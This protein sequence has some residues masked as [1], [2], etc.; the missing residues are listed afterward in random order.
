MKKLIFFGLLFLFLFAYGCNEIIESSESSNPSAS[1]SV[2]ESSSSVASSEAESGE[3][4]ENSESDESIAQSA[5][6][7]SVPAESIPNESSKPQSEESNPTS[8]PESSV[9]PP[10]QSEAG[11]EESSQ[12]IPQESSEAP[13]EESSKTPPPWENTSSRPEESSTTPP[14]EES[15][16]YTPEESSNPPKESKPEESKPEESK[17]EE[18]KP[19]ESKPEESKPEESKP[20]E[21]QPEQGTGDA[22]LL[23]SGYILYNGAAY[24]STQYHADVAQAYA[25]TFARYAEIFP[26]TRI[27]VVTPPQSAI[28]ITNP[29]VAAMTND[30]GIILDQMESHIYGGVNFVNLRKIFES[31]RGEYLFF[32]S[33]FHWTQRGAYYA[34]CAFA[35]SIGLT[36]TPLSSFEEKVVTDQFIGR[37]NETAGD[38]R[39]LSFV[40]TVYA[41]MPTKQHTMTVYNS[42]LDVDRVYSNCIYVKRESY[43]CFI[44]GDQPYTVINVPSNDQ[45]KTALVIKESSGNAFV[46]FL[47]EHYGNI[48]VIDPRHINIDIREL[49]DELGVDDI[50]FHATASTSSRSGYNDYYRALIGE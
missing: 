33:D 7:S 25:D 20:E 9:A 5:A 43:S 17:P 41:Y 16:Q 23:P 26:Y 21:S 1:E 3:S 11:K 42:N 4:G 34:Y 18:S 29:A 48:I 6:E 10:E 8:V 38:D 28:N 13:P 14:P 22:E 39:V 49:V 46:P 36:P 12:Y 15:S 40:D 19:E 44:T 31:H 35:E 47:T 37:A 32:K 24:H 30:Q 45:N 2:H 27:N 50:I